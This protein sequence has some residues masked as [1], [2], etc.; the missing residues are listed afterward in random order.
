MQQQQP[1]SDPHASLP[2]GSRHNWVHEDPSGVAYRV[3]VPGMMCPIGWGTDIS[4][5][6]GL[7]SE[8]KKGVIV[9][10]DAIHLPTFRFSHPAHLMLIEGVVST[11]LFLGARILDLKDP[12]AVLQGPFIL[13]RANYTHLS[14]V[15]FTASGVVLGR[16]LQIPKGVK[17]P[18]LA[19]GMLFTLVTNPK[20]C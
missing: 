6:T 13:L 8:A 9:E 11:W 5:R 1:S 3:A 14:T 2:I 4:M 16:P 15:P 7:T 17:L 19:Q 12:K 20:A 18:E 10:W